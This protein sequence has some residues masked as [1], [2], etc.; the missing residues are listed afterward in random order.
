M[1]GHQAEQSQEYH[2]EEH[3][4]HGAATTLSRALRKPAHM[5]FPIP[6]SITRRNRLPATTRV[7]VSTDEREVDNAGAALPHH[8]EL[9]CTISPTASKRKVTWVQFGNAVCDLDATAVHGG[10]MT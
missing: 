9:L 8:N 5:C 3:C 7:V 4:E 6:S 10:S 2:A 1:S